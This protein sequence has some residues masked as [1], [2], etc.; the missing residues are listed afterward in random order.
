MIL[1][2]YFIVFP[3]ISIYVSSNVRIGNI[4]VWIHFLGLGIGYYDESVLLALA[5]AVG[6]PMK[7][8]VC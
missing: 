8:D 7:V 6:K 1:Y 5:L 2:H 4:L 3:R